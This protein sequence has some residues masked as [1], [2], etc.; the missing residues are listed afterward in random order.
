MPRKN[1]KNRK[2]GRRGAGRSRRRN[3]SNGASSA[4]GRKMTQMS[5]AVV[6][7]QLIRTLDFI[8]Y[9]IITNIGVSYTNNRYKMNSSYDVDPLVG[10]TTLV[11]FTE[12][13][14]LYA[15]YRVLKVHGFIDLCNNEAFPVVAYV[16]PNR[17]QSDPGANSIN[18]L[19]WPSNAMFK[20]HLLSAKG[21]QDRIRIPFSFNLPKIYSKQVLTD[22]NF[23][24]SVTSDPAILVYMICGAIATG[25]NVL[26]VAGVSLD[27]AIR[28]E[29]MFYKPKLLTT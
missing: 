2:G 15:A 7:D 6:P 10:S 13:S 25:S 20:R 28:Q 23:S 3:G 17:N 8:A 5:G 21:G 12:L 24:A 1:R 14:A 16:G 22:D 29:V 27:V 19:E 26:T 11:G 4:S 18:G 9:P